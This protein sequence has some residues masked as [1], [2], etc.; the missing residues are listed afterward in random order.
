MSLS[1][2]CTIVCLF[3][4]S[5]LVNAQELYHLPENK[6]PRWISF[7]NPEGKKGA[8]AM[9]NKGA[10]GH[11]ADRIMPGETVD[12]V[13]Y[14]GSGTVTRIWLTLS[15]RTPEMLR[16]LRIDMYWDG[17]EKPAVSAPIGDFFGCG[18][19]L[20]VPFESALFSDPEGR[21]FNCIIPMPFR[22]NARITI[23]N[24]H[25]E[26]YTTLFYDVDILLEEHDEDALY[27]HTYWS[28][29]LKTDLGEDFEILPKIEGAG[30][31]LGTNIGLI[32]DSLYQ[33]TW[34]G[35]GEAKI[36]LD[37]DDEF[38]TLVGTGT[39][40]YVGTA[41]GQGEFDH[42]YQGS[43]I[44]DPERRIYAF[45]RYHIPDP[46]WFYEDIKVTIQQMGGAPGKKV[47]ELVENGAELI[48]VTV[49]NEKG[50]FKL[51][52]M[53]PVPQL[54][55]PDMPKGWTN[56]Y[57]RDDVSATAYFYLNA[58]ASSLPVL[59]DKESRTANLPSRN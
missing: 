7:E 6:S 58:P 43:L 46:V 28:R 37:G 21:S 9:E 30:R 45:Y 2:L 22:E 53:D 25:P 41:Y 14:A 34:W 55:D 40:D 16:S 20:R 38:A 57:R 44:T 17:S 59:G 5:A 47:M 24:D 15:Q 11:P 23:T 13:N 35:E 33:N 3:F 52:E 50:N 29:D 39:E 48:P 31:F 27:F 51:L 12:L 36:Y 18:L 26:T 19:G 42:M 1:H 54:G 8:G 4:G 10:K 56:F 49:S 32:T